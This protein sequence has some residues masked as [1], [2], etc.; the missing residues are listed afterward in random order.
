MDESVDGARVADLL[1]VRWRDAGRL[2]QAID[3]DAFEAMLR[4]AEVTAVALSTV[5]EKNIG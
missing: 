5:R 1:A 2:I 3:P 4:A